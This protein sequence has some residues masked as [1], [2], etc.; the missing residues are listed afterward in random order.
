MIS[1]TLSDILYQVDRIGL[2]TGNVAID[3]CI[4]PI[5]RDRLGRAIGRNTTADL[6]QS[7]GLVVADDGVQ[8]LRFD[9]AESPRASRSERLIDRV[10]IMLVTVKLLLKWPTHTSQIIYLLVEIDIDSRHC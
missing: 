9:V 8:H 3:T 5:Y 1:S 2:D 10:Q 4:P 6:Y 7:C